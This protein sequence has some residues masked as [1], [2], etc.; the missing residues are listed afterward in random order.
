MNQK[1]SRNKTYL[2]NNVEVR[3]TGRF[4][5]K[6]RTRQK[7][8]VHIPVYEVQPVDEFNGIWKKWATAEELLEILKMEGTDDNQQI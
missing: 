7:Q 6:V 3:L 4:T 2:F 5:R 1:I 8:E